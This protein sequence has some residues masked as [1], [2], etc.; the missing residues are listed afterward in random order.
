MVS[1][2][3]IFTLLVLYQFKHFLADYPLQ[4]KYMLGKF[5][6]GWDFLGPLLAH[7]GVHGAMTLVICLCL[8][9]YLWWLALVDMAIHFAMDRIKASPKYLGRYKAM[10]AAEFKDAAFILKEAESYRADP[11]KYADG[12]DELV[13]TYESRALAQIKSNTYFWWS[14]GLD[15][16]VH[17]LTHYGVIYA[18]LVL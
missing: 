18:L 16:M 11:D 6:P 10:S 8:K 12:S 1:L 5:K 9:P 7:V 2:Y 3:T 4:G 17:H 13:K 15:Q 14:L